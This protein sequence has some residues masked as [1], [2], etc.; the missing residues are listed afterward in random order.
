MK[1]PRTRPVIRRPPRDVPLPSHPEQ[2]EALAHERAVAELGV[3][4]GIGRSA[5]LL[6]GRQ[7]RLAPAIA[8]L[9]E[10][11]PVAP[12]GVDWLQ[13][14]E[15]RAGLHL[16]RG[17][18]WGECEVDDA[19]VSRVVRIEREVR[20]RRAERPPVHDDLTPFDAQANDVGLGD[21]GGQRERENEYGGCAHGGSCPPS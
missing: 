19:G 1:L 3:R 16:A 11:P 20:S 4:R 13:H 15:V 9:V 8:D 18:P 14:V 17:I 5:R 12:R 6:E 10:E 21:R 2:R 7:Q